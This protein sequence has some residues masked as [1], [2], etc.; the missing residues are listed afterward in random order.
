MTTTTGSAG[1]VS[2]EVPSVTEALTEAIRGYR[3]SELP[4]DVLFLAKQCVLDWAG[5]AL[6][7]SREPLTR[8]LLDEALEQGGQAQATVVGRHERLAAQQAALVNGAAS[9]AL[10][11]DD[12]Q[13]TM[14]GHPSVPVVPAL[15]ALAEQRGASGR[16]FL[17]A[18]VAGVEMECRL[19]MLVEPGHYDAGWHATGTLGAFGAA[20]ACAHL[21]GLDGQTWRQALGIAGTQAAGLKSMFGT[22]CKPF[23]AGRAAQNGL[24]AAT[25]AARGFTSNPDVLDCAQGF[26]ATQTS[27][28]NP[29]RALTNLGKTFAIRDVLFKYHAACYGTHATIEGLLRLR[30]RHRLSGDDVRAVRLRISPTQLGV[31][32][33]AEPRTALEG[34]FSLRFT[35]ALALAGADT[36]ERGFTDTIVRDPALTALRDRVTVETGDLRSV[37]ETD[38]TVVLTDGRELIERMDVGVPE[39]DLDRQWRRLADKFRGLAAPVLGEARADLLRTAIE[40]LEEAETMADVAR[41]CAAPA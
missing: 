6:A 32:N 15:L 24:L 16:D 1:A 11:F 30:E 2:T 5:V 18:F 8:I 3:Y 12:V 41:L 23:H 33:I 21:L 37:A 13:L 35:A 14:H 39:R 29:E 7:G 38:V 36:G 10:D 26:T 28:P 22:M 34:K 40:K 17:T 4:A 25:L 27:T 31:C 20:A 19:G 9:H